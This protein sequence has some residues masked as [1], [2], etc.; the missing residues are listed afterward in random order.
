MKIEPYE[1]TAGQVTA[2]HVTDPESN[3]DEV[4]E[5]EPFPTDQLPKI[6]VM[7]GKYYQAKHECVEFMNALKEAQVQFDSVK[8]DF[9]SITRKH[10]SRIHAPEPTS[11][12]ITEPEPTA[13]LPRTLEE[14]ADDIVKSPEIRTLIN[15]NNL[16]DETIKEL[17]ASGNNLNPETFDSIHSIIISKLKESGVIKKSIAEKVKE[18][19]KNKR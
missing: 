12:P 14:V 19:I 10:K 16:T 17:I 1:M 18:K 7:A 2:I 9:E 11:E 13:T 5:T 6:I 3:L 15:N 8:S 4:I